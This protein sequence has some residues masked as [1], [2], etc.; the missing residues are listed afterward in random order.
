M[1]PETEGTVLCRKDDGVV[2]EKGRTTGQLFTPEVL[3]AKNVKTR[4][5]RVRERGRRD[6][7]RKA[8]ER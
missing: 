5:W 1:M 7:A 2:A 3:L 8:E 4:P 6:V